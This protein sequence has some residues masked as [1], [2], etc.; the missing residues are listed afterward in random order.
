[1]TA[2]P[3]TPDA[4]LRRTAWA[5]VNLTLAVTGRRSDGYH[6]LDSL[7]AFPAIGDLIEVESSA[8]LGLTL[9]GTH[10]AALDAGPDNLVLRAALALRS[11]Y[12]RSPSPGAA[13]RL[14]KRLPIASGVGGGSSDAAATLLALNALWGL[15]ASAEALEAIGAGLG[16]D[17][18][19][20]LRA[21]QTCWMR[22]VGEDLAPGPATPDF[23]LALANPG[24]PVATPEVFKALNARAVGEPADAAPE[25]FRDFNE[26]SGWMARQRNDLEA[27][28]QSIAPEI[29]EALAALRAASGCAL[30]RMSGSGAT[31]W[32]LFE[33]GEQAMAAAAAIGEAR[34]GWWTAAGPVPARRPATAA[35]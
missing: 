9:D 29:G 7:V 31:C 21:P 8:T 14:E 10:G 26:F 11:A 23:W 33:R 4:S 20:C 32:G 2:E 27:P 16:A 13:I 3:A 1:M 6:L 35:Q 25:A 17:V 22:G 28:A 34:G 12:P 18:P 19:V 24:V 15:G 5:K 30:A